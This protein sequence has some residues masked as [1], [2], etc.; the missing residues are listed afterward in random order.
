M[1]MYETL[2]ELAIQA[3]NAQG[4]DVFGYLHDLVSK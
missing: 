3:S 4:K 2:N 1:A